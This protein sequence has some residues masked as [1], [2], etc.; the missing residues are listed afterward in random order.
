MYVY[1]YKQEELSDDSAMAILAHFSL[2]FSSLKP[3]PLQAR[4]RPACVRS[5]SRGLQCM[6]R[7]LHSNLC[8]RFDHTSCCDRLITIYV[9]FMWLQFTLRTFDYNS[10]CELSIAVHV[11]TWTQPSFGS[12]DYNSC[13]KY[14]I[15]LM[16]RPFDYNSR[17]VL[18]KRQYEW[19]FLY[20]ATHAWIH[21]HLRSCKQNI[22][23]AHVHA[24]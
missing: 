13:C 18:W 11:V 8:C 23:P 5:W 4:V 19:S 21:G 3:Q 1:I 24:K 15:N 6:L 9:A 20:S 12:F 14:W 2:S 10:C 17:C 16:L 22:L 7:S